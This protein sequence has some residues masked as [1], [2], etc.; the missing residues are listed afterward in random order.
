MHQETVQEIF[1]KLMNFHM[2]CPFS[3]VFAFTVVATVGKDTAGA[4]GAGEPLAPTL[5]KS[6]VEI[7]HH[8]GH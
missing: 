1:E 2:G 6:G 3:Y 7:H 5:S 8:A 4:R